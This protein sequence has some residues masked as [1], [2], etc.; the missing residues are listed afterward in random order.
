MKIHLGKN[1]YVITDTYIFRF[2]SADVELNEQA[3]II[4]RTES[5]GDFR[6]STKDIPQEFLDR[7]NKSGI[8]CLFRILVEKGKM[9][10]FNICSVFL[11]FKWCL[12]FSPN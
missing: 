7:A 1:I 2:F 10:T 4:N 3:C 9:V 6:L 12:I 5:D 8:D 11:C